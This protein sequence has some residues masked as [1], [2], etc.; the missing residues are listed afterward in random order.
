MLE[1]YNSNSKNSESTPAI[2]DPPRPS[3]EKGGRKNH[4]NIA[5]PL[6]TLYPHVGVKKS[7]KTLHMKVLQ[8]GYHH[9]IWCCLT[10]P[11]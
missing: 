2:A 4:P 5:P 10:I 1:P 3:F 8:L 9:L 6:T 11:I 7:C